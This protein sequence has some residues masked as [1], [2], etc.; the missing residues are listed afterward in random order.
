MSFSLSV[1]CTHFS[2]S[3][4]FTFLITENLQAKRRVCESIQFRFSGE[5]F[6]CSIGCITPGVRRINDVRKR[7]IEKYGSSTELQMHL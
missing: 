2:H 1:S 3:Y 5:Y 7:G 6:E 4:F